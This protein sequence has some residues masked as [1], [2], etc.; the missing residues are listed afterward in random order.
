M[1]YEN[2]VY[3]A[4]FCCLFPFAWRRLQHLPTSPAAGWDHSALASEVCL[5]HVRQKNKHHGLSGINRQPFIGK[6]AKNSLT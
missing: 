3:G 4:K 5:H 1:P 2:R 6:T